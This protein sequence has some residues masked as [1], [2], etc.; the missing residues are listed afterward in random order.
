MG[1]LRPGRASTGPA[2]P[3]MRLKRK[4]L[5]STG[6]SATNH[7]LPHRELSIADGANGSR[8]RAPSGITPWKQLSPPSRSRGLRLISEFQKFSLAI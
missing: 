3:A 2:M 4:Q 1:Q 6:N 7:C 5:R 8:E